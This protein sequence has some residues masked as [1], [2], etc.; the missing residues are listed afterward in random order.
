MKC[1]RTPPR[2]AMNVLSTLLGGLVI[3]TLLASAGCTDGDATGTTGAATTGNVPNT[4]VAGIESTDNGGYGEREPLDPVKT[5]GPIFVD[6]Q[7][8]RLALVITGEQLGY[9]EPCGCAGLE[10]Q[11]GGMARRHTFIE[12]LREDR[13]WPVVAVDN[14]ALIRHFGHQAEIKFQTSVSAVNT[15]QYDAIGFGTGDLML[16]AEFLLGATSGG[17]DGRPSPFLSA[18]VALFGFEAEATPR[19]RVVEAGGMKVAITSILGSKYQAEVTNAD[20]VFADPQEALAEI[21]P[22]IDAA[23]CDVHVLLAHATPEES[24]E[25]ARQFPQFDVVVTAGGADEPPA[26]A[27]TI[28]G[29]DAQLIETGHKGMYAIVLGLQAGGHWDYQ[30]VPLD[31]RFDDSP[32]MRQLMTAYQAQLREEGWDGLG[33]SWL[34]HERSTGPDDPAG[35]FVGSKKCGECHTQAYAKWSTTGHFHATESLVKLDPQRQFDPECISCHSTGWA[36]QQY[37]PYRTGFESL[38]TTPHLASN[39]CENCHGPGQAHVEAEAGKDIALRERLRASMRLTSAT[40]EEQVCAKCHDH[41]NSPG[42]IRD[43]FAVYWP[44]IEHKGKK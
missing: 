40:A 37:E 12:Q 30:R 8:P 35:Q 18:N 38:E 1:L 7:A 3:A 11:K 17:V 27:A 24:A 10:N 5:N 6:W 4:Q 42:F 31:S 2:G 33:L 28:E 13:G 39:G 25:L 43:G 9:L 19:F 34:V 36:P 32:E 23:G 16:T 22:Q 44:K 29:S 15:M 41:D 14:G 21:M 20:V 26:E